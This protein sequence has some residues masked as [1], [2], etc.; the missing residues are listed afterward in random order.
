MNPDESN[1][2]DDNLETNNLKQPIFTNFL[3]K[4]AG[5]VSRFGRLGQP[6]I[7]EMTAPAAPSTE[8]VR[9]GVSTAVHL[10]AAADGRQRMERSWPIDR[11]FATA[12][13]RAACVCT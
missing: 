2:D 1:T 13:A 7:N 3:R 8:P 10:L 6:I 12:H 9:R 11:K 4:G 5:T